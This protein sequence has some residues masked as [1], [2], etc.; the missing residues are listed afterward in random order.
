VTKPKVF[1]NP[2]LTPEERRQAEKDMA[3]M[4]AELWKL[5]PIIPIYTRNDDLV[6]THYY[7]DGSRDPSPLELYEKKQKRLK[8]EA[9]AASAEGQKKDDGAK[10]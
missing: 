5:A 9:E 7:P 10:A 8:E 1:Y 3:R 2:S 6:P 4:A